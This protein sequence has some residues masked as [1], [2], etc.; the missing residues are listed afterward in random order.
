MEI[1]VDAHTPPASQTNTVSL[2]Q[3]PTWH[4][5]PFRQPDTSA[6]HPI[7]LHCF[8][9]AVGFLHL[10]H[11]NLFRTITHPILVGFWQRLSVLGSAKSPG[12]TTPTPNGPSCRLSEDLFGIILNA[13]QSN[14]TASPHNLVGKSA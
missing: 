9:T 1:Q 14:S 10:P 8:H 13:V 12:A 3:V 11:F 7:P 5:L 6:R 2:W 4:L